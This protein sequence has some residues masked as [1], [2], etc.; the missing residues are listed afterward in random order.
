[1]LLAQTKAESLRII[2]S[3]FFMLFSILMPLA[4]YFLFASLNGA[5]KSIASTTYGSYSLMSMTAFSLIGTAVS[6]FGIRLAYERRDGWV[7]LLRLTP[8]TPSVWIGSKLIA[9]MGIHLITIIVIFSAAQLTY[10]FDLTLAQWVSC[11][12]W[13]W[14]GS[15]PFLALGSIL[16][17]IKNADA[18]IAIGNILHMGLAI[19]GGL[20][21]PLSTLPQWMQSIGQWLPSYRFAHGAWNMLAGSAPVVLD[22]LIL[23]VS[24]VLF[25]VLSGYILNRRE[26]M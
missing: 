25:M 3:P 7:R 23:V 1:M 22:W 18:S 4:F 17:T 12:L 8:L 2:R 21:M 10:S 16:G 19:L 14:I 6:Q 26:A 9:H 5:D 11:G 24:G 13:L 15:L 20:W